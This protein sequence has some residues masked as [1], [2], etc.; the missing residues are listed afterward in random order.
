MIGL[1]ILN[2]YIFNPQ[3]TNGLESDYCI[4]YIYQLFRLSFWRHPF[5]AEDPSVNMRCNTKFL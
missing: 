1:F 3:G 4:L 2:A 5:T